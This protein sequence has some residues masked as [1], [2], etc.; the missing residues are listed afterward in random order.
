[1]R[2]SG[3]RPVRCAMPPVQDAHL[4]MQTA[5]GK[6]GKCMS[7][8]VPVHTRQSAGRPVRTATSAVTA[9]TPE[10]GARTRRGNTLANF[11]D[12]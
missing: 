2:Q 9:D 4:K 10:P 1:M 11:C 6:C 7:P 12:R 8:V 3:G 5:A